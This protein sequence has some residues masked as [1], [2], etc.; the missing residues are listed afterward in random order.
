M[1][2]RAWRRG[3]QQPFYV[4]KE[5]QLIRLLVSEGRILDAIKE[6]VK[7]ASLGSGA[8]AATLGYICLICGD[9][10]GIDRA[11]AMQLCREAA[12]RDDSYAQYVVAWDE[13]E[14]GNYSEL[15]K[16][17]NRSAKERFPPAI[18]DLGRLAIEGPFR[19]G[20]SPDTAFRF[21]RLAL[22]AGHLMTVM[23]F[24][25]YC[26]AGKFGLV[27]RLFGIAAL[28]IAHVLVTPITWCYPFC[29]NVCAYP[30][31]RKRFLF[32]SV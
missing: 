7:S 3:L 6:L 14:L 21:F 4:P 8:A 23:F 9:L 13:Y 29:L 30:A 12:N 5:L 26:K 18:C 25:K 15:S 16:W 22:L 17:M 10:S 1:G 11:T 27:L 24:L 2:L 31:S 20:F 32:H 28:P 19:S